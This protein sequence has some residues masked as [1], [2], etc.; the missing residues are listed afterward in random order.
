MLKELKQIQRSIDQVKLYSSDR[1]LDIKA[2]VIWRKM[3]KFE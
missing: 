3:A 2:V 1:H